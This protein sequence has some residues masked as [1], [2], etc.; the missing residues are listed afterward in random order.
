MHTFAHGRHIGQGS[1]L[2]FDGVW[3]DHGDVSETGADLTLS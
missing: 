1:N 2:G 3:D